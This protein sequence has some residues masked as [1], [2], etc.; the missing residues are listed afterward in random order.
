[1]GWVLLL[2][3]KDPHE[4]LAPLWLV[5]LLVGSFYIQVICY[6]S[7]HFCVMLERLRATLFLNK[8]EN[9][10]RKLAIFMITITVCY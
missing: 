3:Y 7:L 8:Y 5:S 9:E 10:G 1:M 6:P 4:L 2:Y